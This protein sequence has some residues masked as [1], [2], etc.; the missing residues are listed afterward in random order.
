MND[1]ILGRQA[2]EDLRWREVNTFYC[3]IDFYP[4]HV[5]SS[6]LCL[7]SACIF[8]LSPPLSC[9]II[10]PYVIC[11][12]MMRYIQCT[13]AKLHVLTTMFTSMFLCFKIKLQQKI[14]SPWGVYFPNRGSFEDVCTFLLFFNVTVFFIQDGADKY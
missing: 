10:P 5:S 1:G 12:L 13:I 11:T 7:C 9:T 3:E 14:R 2:A 6:Q 8:T 4:F